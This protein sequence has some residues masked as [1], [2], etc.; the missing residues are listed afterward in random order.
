MDWQEISFDTSADA[1]DMIE[2]RIVDVYE[3]KRFADLAL[4]EAEIY[5]TS[6]SPDDPDGE[7]A[8]LG[9]LLTWKQ[10]QLDAAQT[11]KTS[12]LYAYY[13][14]SSHE[15]EITV[16]DEHHLL[17]PEAKDYLT[18]ANATAN[19]TSWIPVKLRSSLPADSDDNQVCADPFWSSDGWFSDESTTSN[20]ELPCWPDHSLLSSAG[21]AVTDTTPPAAGACVEASTYFRPEGT[22]EGLVRELIVRNCHFHDRY[23]V[24]RDPQPAGYFNR[25]QILE[26]DESGRLRLLLAR[27]D[28]PSPQLAGYMDYEVEWFDWSDTGGRWRVSRVIHTMGNT[29]TELTPQ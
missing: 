6:A 11:M 1:V 24:M 8:L 21:L 9:S 5:V 15:G 2:L 22:Q 23:V 25:D 28:A 4:S 14:T 18:R 7:K 29:V 13:A 16:D 3:G 10:T 27:G 26:Y 17:P 20:I 12:P 19:A